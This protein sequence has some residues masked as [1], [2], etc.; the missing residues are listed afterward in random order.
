MTL[1]NLSFILDDGLIFAL[2][3][4][5]IYIA[6]Q[7]LR[8]PDLTPDGSFVL[9]ACA[10]VKSVIIGVPPIFA[11]IISVLAGALAGCCTAAVNRFVKVPA[12]VAGL[13]VSAGL[14]SIT[15]LV[16]NQPNQFLDPQLTLVGNVSGVTAAWFLLVWLGVISLFVV[17]FLSVL[18]GSVWGLRLRAL[19]ENP[20][21]AHDLGA[22]MTR[23]TFFA[24]ALANGL[25]GLAGALFAQRSYSVDINMGIGITITGLAGM[26]LGLLIARQR[27]RLPQVISFVILG[28]VLYRL[29]VFLALEAGL[30][31]ESFRLVTATFLIVVFFVLKT[32]GN[33]LL[34]G[35][36]WN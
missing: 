20:L 18:G 10:Y 36:K 14:Y 26:L 21:L 9:G 11:L 4:I 3:A 33:D 35:L 27:R 32:S 5:G 30:P 17:V 25:V 31:A 13:V 2:L 16:L 34:R 24:L 7:W 22:S 6:F 1:Y 8:F 12:V 23:Y 28:A 19:G 29:V 15:W